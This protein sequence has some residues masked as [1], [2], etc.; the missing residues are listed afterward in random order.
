[1][2]RDNRL[3]SSTKSYQGD[4][5]LLEVGYWKWVSGEGWER[6]Q[7]GPCDLVELSTSP[8]PLAFADWMP[9]H[10]LSPCHSQLHLLH[11]KSS[12]PLTLFSLTTARF[13]VSCHVPGILLPQSIPPCRIGSLEVST[14]SLLNSYR[15]AQLLRLYVQ[16]AGFNGG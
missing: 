12:P 8:A 6:R 5:G 15:V 7:D 13:G 14:P 3:A 16:A 11:S 10:T 4:G 9:Y 2:Y 1:M